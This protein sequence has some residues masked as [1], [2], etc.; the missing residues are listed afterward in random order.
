MVSILL[1]G[2]QKETPTQITRLPE[3]LNPARYGNFDKLPVATAEPDPDGVSFEGIGFAA[4]GGYIMVQFKASVSQSQLWQQ[5]YIYI[6]D[7]ATRGV[8][9]DI[10]IMPVV[11]PL[12]GRPS[13]EGQTG[14][15]MLLNYYQGI[16]NGSVVTVVLGNYKREHVTVTAPPTAGQ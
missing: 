4:D 6:V 12:I 3:V 15:V 16:K 2:C 7:E 9:K 8:Y 11:G 13:K 14:Y 1:T 5:D 10:P